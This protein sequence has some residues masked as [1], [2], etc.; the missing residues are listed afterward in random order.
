MM[1]ARGGKEIVVKVRNEIGLLANLSKL[2]A[3]KGINITAAAGWVEGEN[4][5]IH[6]VT[7]DNLR[8]VDALRA[9]NYNPKEMDVVLTEVPHKPGMLRHVTEALAK[10][11]IDI[12]HLYATNAADADKGLVVFACANNDR[13][14]VLLNAAS[15]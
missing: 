10:A 12:H 15:R 6:L 11:G 2:I 5:M 8:A 7:E 1:K 4:A 3:D 14:V 9:K 13:A